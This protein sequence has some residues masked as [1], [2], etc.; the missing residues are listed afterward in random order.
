MRDQL[1]QRVK[2][3]TA[4]L[5]RANR[6]LYE[7]SYS[8]SHDL[9]APLRAVN[10][11]SKLLAEQHANAIDAEGARY[12]DVIQK[13]SQHMGRMIDDY[14]R[15]LQLRDEPLAIET[16]NVDGLVR[17]VIDVVT[18][19]ANNRV[20]FDIGPLPAVA[21]DAALIRQLWT[22]LLANAV[23]FTGPRA[24]PLIEIGGAVDADDVTYYIKDNGVGF[25]MQWA[26]QLFKIFQRL[27][28]RQF[29]GLGT[30]LATAARIVQRHGG[31]IQ[32]QGEVDRGAT[33]SFTLPRRQS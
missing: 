28:P 19:Q 31:T 27:H 23:K 16:L 15:L 32:A 8:M 3:R 26:D 22:H 13:N 9:R 25:D 2:A 4:D 20:H 21:G 7:M 6:E 10:G 12:V 29:D 30:G 11:F 18:P 17:D 5:E 14:L 33:F 24:K 1:E